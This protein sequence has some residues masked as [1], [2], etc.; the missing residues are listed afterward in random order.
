VFSPTADEVVATASADTTV[1]V[2]DTSGRVSLTLNGHADTVNSVSFSTDGESLVSASAD[3]TVRL[4]K[5]VGTVWGILK[6]HTL[7]VNSAAF[8]PDGK[9]VVSCSNDQTVRIWDSDTQL[10]RQV[11]KLTVAVRSVRFPAAVDISRPT[12]V[13]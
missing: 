8:S 1:R 4:W 12:E 10:E 11:L 7:P 13:H 6:G 5:T 3:S 2:W 9:L